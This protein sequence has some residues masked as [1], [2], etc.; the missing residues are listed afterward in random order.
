M[1]GRN[2]VLK[3]VIYSLVLLRVKIRPEDI[4]FLEDSLFSK[5]VDFRSWIARE[6]VVP[7]KGKG[8]NFTDVHLF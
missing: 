3:L 5:W 6:I 2:F 1:C 4:E 7:Y 8:L